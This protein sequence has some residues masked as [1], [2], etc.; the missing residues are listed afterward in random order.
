MVVAVVVVVVA[1]VGV[2]VA[3]AS[4]LRLDYSDQ[5]RE[6]AAPE[7]VGLWLLA[8][9]QRSS[10]L[11]LSGD[12]LAYRSSSSNEISSLTCDDYHQPLEP[13]SLSV[14]LSPVLLLDYGLYC[15]WMI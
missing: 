11:G 3:A 8:C 7:G 13:N 1:A 5:Y 9:Q 10:D 15:L 12:D 6:G 14:L 2:A 4:R